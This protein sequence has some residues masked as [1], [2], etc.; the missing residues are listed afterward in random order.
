[1]AGVAGTQNAIWQHVSDVLLPYLG[2]TQGLVVHS[3]E[4]PGV[5][6]LAQIERID[7]STGTLGPPI[8]FPDGVAPLAVSP[9]FRHV[10]ARPAAER[11]HQ[12]LEVWSIE[13]K[14]GQAL[15]SRLKEMQPFV[16]AAAE[17]SH[18]GRITDAAFIDGD[19]IL[20]AG[21]ASELTMIDVPALKVIWTAKTI[22]ALHR[23]ALSPGRG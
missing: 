9:D 16:S 1:M 3:Q 23:L 15:P 14:P 13:P 2:A 10:L 18:T 20:V 19:H 7:F 21:A 11:E 22:E 12:T 8:G 4:G 5:P 6:H 17:R